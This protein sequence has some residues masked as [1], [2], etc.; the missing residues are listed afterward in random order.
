MLLVLALRRRRVAHCSLLI[1]LL[2]PPIKTYINKTGDW[3]MMPNIGNENLRSFLGE[4]TGYFQTLSRGP[5]ISANR[6]FRFY[7]TL[8]FPAELGEKERERKQKGAPSCKRDLY[9]WAH[10]KRGRRGKTKAAL[11]TDKNTIQS[12]GKFLAFLKGTLEFWRG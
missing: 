3:A 1:Q 9:S 7:F 4:I 2:W 8:M 12:G 6:N 11:I 5:P 10:R